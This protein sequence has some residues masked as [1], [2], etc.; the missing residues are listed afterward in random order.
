MMDWGVHSREYFQTYHLLLGV[1][2]F[3][4]CALCIN[5]VHAEGAD[6]GGQIASGADLQVV[7]ITNTLDITDAGDI[8]LGTIPDERIVTT[9]TVANRGD[10]TA[11]GFRI[12]MFLVKEGREDTIDSQLGGDFSDTLLGPGEM[13]TYSKSSVLSK[14]IKPGNYK[15]MVIVDTTPYFTEANT[16][17]NKF[18]DATVIPVGKFTDNT[19]VTPVYSPCTISSP[20]TYV[21][22]RD[23]DGKDRLDGFIKITSSGV[24]LDGAGHTI[25][26]TA[27]GYITGIYVDGNTQLKEIT[28]KNVVIEGVDCGIWL[29]K[30]ESGKIQGCTIQNCRNMGIRFDQVRK[31]EISGNMVTGNEL[32]I[33]LFQSKENTLFNNYLKNSFNAAVNEGIKNVWSIA[34]PQPGQNI[35]GGS[36][37]GGNAW[38]DMNGSGFTKTY[39]DSSG[40]GIADVPFPINADNID[41]YPLTE[42]IAPIISESAIPAVNSSEILETDTNSS[43]MN[44][45]IPEEPVGILVTN[46]TPTLITETKNASTSSTGMSSVKESADLIISNITVADSACLSEDIPI[47][48]TVENIGSLNAENFSIHYYLAKSPSISSSDIDIGHQD[49]T[50]LKPQEARELTDTIQLS[51]STG[52]QGYYL[53][54]IVDPSNDVYEE[55]KENNSKILTNRLSVKAC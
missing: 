10:R 15:L 53:G 34:V 36:M 40:D 54:V 33:G 44:D 17:N 49:L 13:K 41:F 12:K 29:Y 8:P 31:Y 16:D 14:H 19:G 18:T 7:N 46:T 1:V 42:S 48:F 26:G 25:K 5:G 23:I 37:I 55:H 51:S 4:I 11:S 6:P 39:P 3:F 20:G 22:R 50:L 21:L 2:V 43:Q 47:A 32:G 24:I 35:I 9:L 45:T 27:S 38:Y 28:I 30:V 52:I